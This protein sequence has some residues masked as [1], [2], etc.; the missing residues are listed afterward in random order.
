M[1]TASDYAGSAHDHARN[2]EITVRKLNQL[3]ADLS[4]GDWPKDRA[5][6]EMVHS[7]THGPA[8]MLKHDTEWD[9]ATVLEKVLAKEL[10][11][12]QRSVEANQPGFGFPSGSMT[13]VH[14]RQ[15]LGYV[16]VTVPVTG[17]PTHPY[18]D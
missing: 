12:T 13:T 17:D 9:V 8:I 18:I 6:F 11:R 7:L 10:P 3:F 15:G 1:A 4:E 16:P 5:P 14:R 2:I